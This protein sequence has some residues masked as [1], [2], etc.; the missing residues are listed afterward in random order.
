LDSDQILTLI[1][2]LR[3]AGWHLLL[4]DDGGGRGRN[5]AE[6]RRGLHHLG[7]LLHLLHFLHILRFQSLELSDTQSLCALNTSPELS[8]LNASPDGGGRGGNEAKLRR[9]I[10][11]PGRLFHLLHFLHILQ[12]QVEGLGYS[13]LL[14]TEF[15]KED[16]AFCLTRAIIRTM[17]G[18]CYTQ[19]R[20]VGCFFETKDTHRLR[21][22]L[23]RAS[24]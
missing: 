14:I 24:H 13:K 2:L 7:R 6:L 22:L 15:I 11:H 5:E 20:K 10:D 8:E 12:F 3:G 1:P 19:S 17:I 23:T 18:L 21:V 9:G 4:L 16:S